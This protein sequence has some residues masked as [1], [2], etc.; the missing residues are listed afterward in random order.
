MVSSFAKRLLDVIV[1]L[2]LSLKSVATAGLMEASREH[3]ELLC[4]EVGLVRFHRWRFH[5]W[6]RFRHWRRPRRSRPCHDMRWMQAEAPV[7]PCTA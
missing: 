7:P 4:F 5:C 6:P 1:M 2:M 3:L